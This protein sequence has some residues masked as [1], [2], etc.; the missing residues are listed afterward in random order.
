MQQVSALAIRVEGPVVRKRWLARWLPVRCGRYASNSLRQWTRSCECFAFKVWDPWQGQQCDSSDGGR[1][2]EQA[3][4]GEQADSL[5]LFAPHCTNEDRLPASMWGSV[6]SSVPPGGKQAKERK[7]AQAGASRRARWHQELSEA[8][9]WM[10]IWMWG[11]RKPQ[12]GP[13]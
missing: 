2:S 13:I 10:S 3:L 6:F 12:H 9:M 11:S 8:R 1:G 4:A 5:G 7:D